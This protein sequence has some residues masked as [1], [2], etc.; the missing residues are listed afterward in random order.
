MHVGK[1]CRGSTLVDTMGGTLMALDLKGQMESTSGPE[2]CWWCA[3][4]MVV[5]TLVI[6]IN[7]TV[8][9]SMAADHIY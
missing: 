8:L 4:I 9:L 6:R 5:I 3:V 2:M 7:V 1:N